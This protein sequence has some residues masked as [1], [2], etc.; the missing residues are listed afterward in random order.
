MSLITSRTPLRVSFFGGGTDYPEYFQRYTGAVLGCAINQYIYI[1][2]LKLE[3]FIGYSYRLSYRI[4][5]EVNE[6]DEI[7]HPVF[8]E[9]FKWLK[10]EKG[11]NFGVL[12]SL[13]ARSGLGSSS[14]FTVG[15]LHL[16]SAIRQSNFTRYDLAQ[17]AMFVERELLRENVG[18]QDQIHAS[19]GSLNR[20]EF[21]GN[22][23]TI[24]PVRMHSDTRDQI[25]S[26]LYLVHTGVQRY[27]SQV[28]QEQVEKTKENR[29]D[30]ELSDLY[31]LTIT[32]QAA[33]ELQDPECAVKEVGAL[34]NQAW[35]IK[36]QLTKS[37][38]NPDID[39]IYDT[40]MSAGALGGK[41]CGAGGGGFVLLMVPPHA[42][43]KV[44]ES[45]GDRKLI[46]IQ[47]DEVGSV[48]LRS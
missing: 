7:E 1:S 36:R 34:L 44:Q 16:L 14:S 29:I 21:K 6:H 45:L 47:M 40:A 41:L 31:A 4:I 33:F 37:I 9:V 2:A 46:P 13:P 23:F 25:N 24:H 48:I 17:T 8:R 5:E 18:V 11:W 3:E 27:A 43:M 15:L 42:K 20:Y 19:Y 39:A 10:F 35:K 26:S 22:Q 30:R 38:S 12:S 28:V 32:G